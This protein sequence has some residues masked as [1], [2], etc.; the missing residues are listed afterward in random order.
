M[1][2]KSIYDLLLEREQ[3]LAKERDL[4]E[5]SLAKIEEHP[6][7]NNAIS[8]ISYYQSELAIIERLQVELDWF[9]EQ[10]KCLEET[11]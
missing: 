9:I 3:Q 6:L 2:P 4:A 1:K 8:H 10:A 5:I 11:T 7:V